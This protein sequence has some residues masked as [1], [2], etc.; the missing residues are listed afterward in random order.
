MDGSKNNYIEGGNLDPRRQ[1]LYVF[2]HLQ[3]LSPK[4]QILLNNM[5][6]PQKMD[7]GSGH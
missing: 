2:F 4:L 5:E 7:H 3:F 6:L 1:I